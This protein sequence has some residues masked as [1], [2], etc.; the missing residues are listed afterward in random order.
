MELNQLD[1]VSDVLPNKNYETL[2]LAITKA[3]CPSVASQ[4]WKFH[5]TMKLG[6]RSPR[7]LFVEIRS[8]GSDIGRHTTTLVRRIA[9]NLSKRAC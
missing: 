7:E 4:R 1:F 9:Y 8:I 6:D 2:K 5:S 3:F